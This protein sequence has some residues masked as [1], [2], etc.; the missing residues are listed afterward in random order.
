MNF[1]KAEQA[2][3]KKGIQKFENYNAGGQKDFQL[4]KGDYVPEIY[5][6]GQIVG[7][8]DFNVKQ[9]GL[10]VEAN[11]D[12]GTDWELLAD[13]NLS[14]PIQTHTA[15]SDEEGFHV[16][17]HPFEYH[18]RAKSA[19]DWPKL[20]MKVLR[21][22]EMGKH[23]YIAYGVVNLP[24]TT[25]SFDLECPT[26]RPMSGWSEESYNF[27]LGGP[28]KLTRVDPIVKN[29]DQRKYLTTVSSGTVHVQCDVILKHFD[30][31]N[32]K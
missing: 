16:F 18:F 24:S 26:W 22:D 1:S 19:Q 4:K 23:D 8:V 31:H 30:S 15:Y 28:P 32:I 9:D 25:G 27:Y 14:G 29:L 20:T 21:L 7:G 12:Y 3:V 6:I 2:S 17:A 11:L 5:F 10:F 13:D